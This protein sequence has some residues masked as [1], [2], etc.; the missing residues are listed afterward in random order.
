MNNID[1]IH[2]K[3][4]IVRKYLSILAPLQKRDF[5]DLER[6]VISIGATERYLYLVT[7]ATIDL[8]EAYISYRNYRKPTRLAESFEI[9]HE[10]S[11]IDVSLVAHLCNMT[12]FRNILSHQ[13][14]KIDYEIVK[15]VLQTG[16]SHI[17]TFLAEI[18]KSL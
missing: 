15:N 1:I 18:E 8:A 13:Y 6:D 5:A 14:T 2:D 7:Q 12:G 11:V 9:L 4:S 16:L 10:Q 3:V 17:E